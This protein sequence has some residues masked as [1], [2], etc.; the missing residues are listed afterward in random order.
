M[1]E[2]RPRV[3][4][5]V[6]HLMGVGHLHR[7]ARIVQAM[8]GHGMVVDMILG[9]DPHTQVDFAAESV[10]HLPP[11]RAQDATYSIMLDRE[12]KPL[13]ETYMNE[14]KAALLDIAET[15][16]PDAVI[17]EA[18]PF[19]RR[20]VR[21]EIIAM[22]EMF[23]SREPRPLIISSVRDILQENRKPGRLEEARD[24][25]VRHFDRVLVHSDPAVVPLDATFPLAREF[26]ERIAY[27]G[28]VVPAKRAGQ[29]KHAFDVIVSAGGGG[30]GDALMKA[31][32]EVAIV[33]DDLSWC[34]STGVNGDRDWRERVR[35]TAPAHVAIVE[36]LDDL[37]GH[38]AR[39]KLSISQCGYNTAMD[40]LAA[41]DSG[42]CRAVF[43]PHDT[44][45]QTEQLR[46]A[47]L[48]E[49][50]GRAVCLPESSLSPAALLQ[51]MDRV[52]AMPPVSG[53]VDFAGAE[54]SA[55]LIGRWIRERRC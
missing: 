10:H 50:V 55:E 1:A 20:V 3:L 36:Q 49:E 35:K 29:V 28:F 17:V 30:F 46:R 15:L 45:G 9:G 38:L 5:Y 22:L 6:L 11:I 51:S 40:V 43:V 42:K 14:R 26:P 37:A 33:R 13:G 8:T 21:D 19:G 18:F 2:H 7:A 4:F 54:K 25:V 34:I 12:G 16:R 52:L 23:E 47:K 39:A 27:T 48:F 32:F 24:W 41:Q 44:T 31:A 53:T